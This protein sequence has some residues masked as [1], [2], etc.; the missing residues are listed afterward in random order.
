M[1]Q[2]SEKAKYVHEN[3]FLYH[4]QFECICRTKLRQLIISNI[5]PKFLI[6]S[7][8]PVKLKKYLLGRQR[9]SEPLF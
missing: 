8:L 1:E 3:I 7:Q 2:W 5:F 6:Y 4:I 9:L